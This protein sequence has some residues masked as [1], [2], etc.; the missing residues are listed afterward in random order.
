MCLIR[1]NY[2]AD[3]YWVLG[4]KIHS[5]QDLFTAT[6]H[7]HQSLEGDDPVQRCK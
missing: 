3:F 5:F 6:A 2:N 1:I 7:S 4:E